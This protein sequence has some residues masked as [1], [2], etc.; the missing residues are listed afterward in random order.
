MNMIGKKRVHKSKNPARCRQGAG[1]QCDKFVIY[2][3]DR[4]CVSLNVL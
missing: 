1:F 4:Y 3:F 2:L